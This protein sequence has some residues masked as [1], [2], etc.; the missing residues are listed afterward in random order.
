[1]RPQ[2][3]TVYCSSTT[4]HGRVCWVMFLLPEALGFKIA[5][6]NKAA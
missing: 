2:I 5:K 1:M 6:L 4:R 3:E